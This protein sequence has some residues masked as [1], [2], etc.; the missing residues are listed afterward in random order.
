MRYLKRMKLWCSGRRQSC[1]FL[2]KKLKASD[3]RFYYVIFEHFPQS[4]FVFVYS[5]CNARH[6]YKILFSTSA[7][8]GWK[9]L[10]FVLVLCELLFLNHSRT[11]FHS[12][13]G[14]TD[15]ESVKDSVR[16]LQSSLFALGI[17]WTSPGSL[18][19]SPMY[20]LNRPNTMSKY[21]K[22][23]R[24]VYTSPTTMIHSFSFST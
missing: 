7:L 20:I 22:A 19:R 1:S 2:S 15:V 24:F 4:Q 9:K 6:W 8:A 14:I 3:E 23:K 10:Q 16:S 12:F 21:M 17:W 18:Y 11:R 13:Y 5:W